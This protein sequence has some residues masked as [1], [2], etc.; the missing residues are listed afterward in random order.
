MST[1]IVFNGIGYS[2][3]LSGDSYGDDLSNYLVAIA[4]GALQKTGGTFTLSG[5]INFGASYG[6]KLPYIK[7]QASNP[8]SSGVVRLGNTESVSWRNAANNADISLNVNASDKLTYNSIELVDL[9]ST[10]TLTNKTLTNPVLSSPTGLTKSDVGLSNVDNTSD[11]TKNAAAV[12]LTNKT[13][14]ASS[15]D[16]GTW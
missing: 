4:S 8:S 2:I 10:Q 11:A 3:P 14:D 15:I 1:S 5:E 7:S 13:I 12:T 16:G 6:L 9:S